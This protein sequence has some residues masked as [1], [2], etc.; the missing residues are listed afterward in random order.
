MTDYTWNGAAG[1]YLDPAQWTPAEVPLYGAGDTATIGA[2]AAALRNAAPNNLTLVLGEQ[3]GSPDPRPTLAL[4]N[5]ALGADL[6]LDAVGQA[7]LEV[8]G[9]DTSYGTINVL[10]PD[11]AAG[12][13]RS[14]T[15]TVSIGAGSQL[16][17]DGLIAVVSPETVGSR[18]ASLFFT[19]GGTLNNDG[20]ITVGPGG[21][22]T[23]ELRSASP[24]AVTGSGTITV[25]DATVDLFSAAPT[26]T[27]DLLGGTLNTSVSLAAA[28]KDWDDDGRLVF[29]LAVGVGAVR[30]DQT[31]AEGGDLELFGIK[32][33]PVGTLH[34]LG[35]YATEDFTVAQTRFG[36][37]VGLTGHPPAPA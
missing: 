18:G 24:Y 1:D 11:A 34:L 9:Y 21:T 6:T 3:P 8:V 12:F 4:D 2:G 10:P 22:A 20:Q 14:D 29:G 23:F 5:A 15:L 27:V 16:N 37:S 31:S 36:S 33:Q 28:I 25:D 7:L 19:G 32:G 26:Q 30:F 13:P 35:S 17:Q